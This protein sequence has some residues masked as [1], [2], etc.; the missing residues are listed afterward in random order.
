MIAVL[1]SIFV[2]FLLIILSCYWCL[3]KPCW[4]KNR[5][6]HIKTNKNYFLNVNTVVFNY[7]LYKSYMSV[8]H[9]KISLGPSIYVYVFKN[10]FNVQK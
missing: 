6:I 4:P 10:N 7:G 8:K 1:K 3:N 2:S 9:K 5:E